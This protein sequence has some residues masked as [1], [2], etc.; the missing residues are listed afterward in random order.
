MKAFGRKSAL[1]IL[2]RSRKGNFEDRGSPTG[3][4]ELEGAVDWAP[5][6]LAAAKVAEE[7]GP[8]ENIVD[9][10]TV[11]HAI[12]KKLNDIYYQKLQDKLSK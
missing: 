4:R 3:T 7:Q 2:K 9:I 12:E 6:Q 8:S 11:S 5:D 1:A 10:T